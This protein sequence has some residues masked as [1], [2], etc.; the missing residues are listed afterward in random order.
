MT[1]ILKEIERRIALS[2]ESAKP[3]M[4]AFDAITYGVDHPYFRILDEQQERLK[5]NKKWTSLTVGG[6]YGPQTWNTD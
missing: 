6:A 4:E 1:D 3:M 2:G 5:A